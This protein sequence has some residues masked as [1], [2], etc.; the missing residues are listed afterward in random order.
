[1]L[2]YFLLVN[3]TPNRVRPLIGVGSWQ[4]RKRADSYS[5]FV[6]SLVKLVLRA[7]SPKYGFKRTLGGKPTETSTVTIYRST[8]SRQ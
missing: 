4:I 6:G 5:L 2:E 7:K 3:S 1:M 8:D